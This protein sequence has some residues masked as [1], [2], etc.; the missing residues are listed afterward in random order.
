MCGIAAVANSNIVYADLFT[1][2]QRLEYRGYDSRGLYTTD[3]KS[4]Y[5]YWKTNDN[6]IKETSLLNPNHKYG[7]GH[8]RW[9]T[10]G[11]VNVDNA[12]PHI[13]EHFVIAH[14]G[15]VSNYQE[16]G[17]GDSDS[18]V[19]LNYI[20]RIY[21]D[22]NLTTEDTLQNIYRDI[23]GDNAIVLICKNRPNQIWFLT[24]GNKEL[25]IIRKDN[26]AYISSDINSLSNFDSSKQAS[27]VSGIGFVN[28]HGHISST[29]TSM[30]V[31]VGVRY[32]FVDI[33]KVDFTKL[34]MI[35]EI[36]QQKELAYHEN[37]PEGLKHFPIFVGCGSSYNAALFGRRC[38]ELIANK[39][40]MAEY[41]SEFKNYSG[42]YEYGTPRHIMIGLSQSG[43]TK[44]TIDAMGNNPY[45]KMVITNNKASTLARKFFNVNLN[46]G[47]EMGVAATKTFTH[48]CL[49]LLRMAC[50]SK[51]QTLKNLDGDL[52]EFDTFLKHESLTTELSS[53]LSK[54][55]K[56]QQFVNNN[57]F[58]RYLFLGS[59]FNYP[60]AREA[61]LK[62]KEISYIP[63]EG[64]PAAEMKHGPI[65]LVDDK[66]LSVFI[67]PDLGG[68]E[69][70]KIVQNI[71]EVHSRG[72]KIAV[73]G[74]LLEKDRD[75]C[76][77]YFETKIVVDSSVIP[78]HHVREE[79]DALS[80]IL[81]TIPLQFLAYFTAKKL[82]YDPDRPRNLAKTVT[83]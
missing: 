26:K 22:N 57:D 25:Y 59:R 56:I 79:V 29:E 82:G 54:A 15:I 20:E 7:I 6:A 49:S 31:S 23:T 44:D 43:E 76:N 34:G 3:W 19:L 47:P 41:A 51:H 24:T 68:N 58:E 73:V 78:L 2:L 74:S 32:S 52:S 72:S 14:N 37:S 81:A 35:N 4:E 71:R 16:L 1:I 53:I 69:Y 66:C 11:E 40:A 12:H 70:E 75:L 55:D 10:H 27:C 61:A 50:N 45:S 5:G 64:M 18:I 13:G 77:F 46:C 33:P 9:A 60:I 39:P 21:L 83:V 80:A 28:K 48:T 36:Y 63:A 30:P 65:A 62:M 42:V 17:K 67:M 8:T 38:F